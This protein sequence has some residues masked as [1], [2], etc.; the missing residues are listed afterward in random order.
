MEDDVC[1]AFK[2]NPNGS[3]S[4]IEAVTIE[5]GSG[6]IQ[7]GPGMYF[8]RGVKFMGVDLAAWLDEKCPQTS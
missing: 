5:S 6:K 2:R 3:W 4:C 8:S 7:I 1:A